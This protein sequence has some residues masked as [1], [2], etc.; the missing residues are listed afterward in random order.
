MGEVTPFLQK[1]N[2]HTN[3]HGMRFQIRKSKDGQYYYVLIAKNGKILVT[4]E[5]MTKKQS[6]EQGIQV[7]ADYLYKN[8]VVR[9]EDN[10]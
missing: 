6:C 10:T 3:P 5:T 8:P 1:K 4:S 7:I 9:I 2:I